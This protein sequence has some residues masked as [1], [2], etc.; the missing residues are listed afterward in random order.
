MK[1]FYSVLIGLIVV[2]V[3]ATALFTVNSFNKSQSAIPQKESFSFTIK[4]W[5]N[6]FRLLDKATS[7]AIIDNG[8]GLTCL[9]TGFSPD[10]N[11]YNYDQNVLNLINSDC[12]IRNFAVSLAGPVNSIHSVGERNIYDINVMM[13]LKCMHEIKIG[14][15]IN[16]LISFDKNIL[17]EKTIDA[18]YRTDNFDCNITVIDKQSNLVDINYFIPF[19]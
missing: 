16:S 4:E 2:V 7:D 9:S 19:P 10:T 1:G 12:I 6:T 15:D 13:D 11:I 17:F 8:F 14:K 3:L 18:N 5:H